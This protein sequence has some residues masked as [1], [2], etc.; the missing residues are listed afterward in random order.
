MCFFSSPKMPDPIVHPFTE[1]NA[2]EPA[3]L[4]LGGTKRF[5]DIDDDDLTPPPASIGEATKPIKSTAKS[6]RLLIPTNLTPSSVAPSA[7]SQLGF[8]I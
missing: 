6:S 4:I 3:G 7:S 8:T 2:E 5:K 1:T